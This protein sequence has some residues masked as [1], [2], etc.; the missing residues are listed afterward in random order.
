MWSM[1]RYGSLLAV[2][3]GGA[4][5]ALARW[6]A[7]AAVGPDRATLT[8]FALNV[9][10]SAIVGVLAARAADLPSRLD[11]LVGAGFAGGLT[12][13]STFSLSVARSLDEGAM[14]DA[15]GLAVGTLTSTLLTAGIA[16]R[17]A[18]PSTGRR[19]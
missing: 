4:V 8:V 1:Q 17:L 18:R 12:T 5:G 2:A 13:F 9:V 7:V 6:Q 15:L 3:L 11:Q 14:V 16:Y 19:S 10:G